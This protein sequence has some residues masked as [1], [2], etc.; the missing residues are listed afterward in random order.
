M[1]LIGKVQA[2]SE[3][4]GITC[5]AIED[6]PF[7]TKGYYLFGYLSLTEESEFDF[8][9]ETLVLAMQ[10]AEIDWGVKPDDWQDE[11]ISGTER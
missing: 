5:L 10:Q 8:W 2:P 6:D 1:R 7:D 3:P 9:F 11:E 4:N